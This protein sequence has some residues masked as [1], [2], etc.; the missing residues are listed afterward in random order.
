MTEY[1]PYEPPARAPAPLPR[2]AATM[3]AYCPEERVL[4]LEA[5]I[6]DIAAAVA[7]RGDLEDGRRA[8]SLLVWED[9]LESTKIVL[10]ALGC[11]V[12]YMAQP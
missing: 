4:E 5:R 10:E 2:T 6:Q 11:N 1:A 7:A 8:Y 9:S 3:V 12:V